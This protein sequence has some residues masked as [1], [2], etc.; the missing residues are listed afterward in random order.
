VAL[1]VSLGE[2]RR[3][4]RRKFARV[5]T[6]RGPPTPQTLLSQPRPPEGTITVLGLLTGKLVRFN[7]IRPSMSAYSC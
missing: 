4:R 2:R 1:E 7:A 5:R 3:R 6:C